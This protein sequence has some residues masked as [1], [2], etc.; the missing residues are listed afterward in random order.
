MDSP[1]E[2]NPDWSGEKPDPATSYANYRVFN[3]GNSTPVKLMDFVEAIEKA[4][5]KKAVK[6]FMPLQAGDVRSTCADVSE[7][8]KAVAFRPNTPIQEGIA[9]FVDWYRS[10]FNK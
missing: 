8:E 9:N 10:Y 7:L 2:G 6:N 5:G 4:V 3:I 1:P